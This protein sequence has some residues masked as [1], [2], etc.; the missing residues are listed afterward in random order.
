MEGIPSAVFSSYKSL[1]NLEDG[2]ELGMLSLARTK[3]DAFL[4][5][6]KKTRQ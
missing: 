5:E 4:E 6:E 2:V 1:L 3:I